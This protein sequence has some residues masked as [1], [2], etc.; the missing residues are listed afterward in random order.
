M[1]KVVILISGRGSNMQAILE[2][3]LPVTVAAVISNDAAAGG[4]ATLGY[5]VVASTFAVFAEHA[6]DQ[7][8][9]SVAQPRLNVKIVASQSFTKMM[10][11]FRSVAY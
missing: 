9:M 6:Y 1:K 2:A 11:C 3:R 10:S 7:L 8:R 4:L 5:S